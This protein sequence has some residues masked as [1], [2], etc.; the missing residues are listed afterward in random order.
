LVYS[1]LSRNLSIKRNPYK[2]NP[3]K[4]VA[5]LPFINLGNDT[6]DQYIY[7]GIRDEIFNNLRKVSTLRVISHTTVEQ[8][9]NTT[10]TIREIGKELDVNYIVKGSGQKSGNTSL[11][12]VSLIEVSSDKHIWTDSY[13]LEL[14]DIKDLFKNQSQVAQI[15][16]S[17]LNATITPEEKELIEKVPTQ[18]KIAYKLYWKA[19]SYEKDYEKSRDLS[20]YQTAVNL[21][22][23]TLEIDTIFARAYSGLALTYWSRYY[24]ETYFKQKFL[25]SCHILADK[26]LSFDDKLEEAYYLKGR[27]YQENGTRYAYKAKMMG[28]TVLVETEIHDFVL[29]KGWIGKGTKGIPSQIQW[30]FETDEA[31]TKF[32][33]VLEYKLPIP[34][35]SSIFDKL[36][37]KP[38][39]IKIIEKSL[40][41]L[42]QKF[43]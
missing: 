23:Y 40:Q 27:Y 33:Y 38:Q 20:S 41:N 42:N 17:E 34:L 4:S 25:D 3:E 37:M 12:R 35:L 36:I 19:N 24:S 29:N 22:K 26:A 1:A 10:K 28:L 43:Q 13:E 31:G 14:M 7:D 6:T 21:Y 8:Y 15:I 30:I 39:W 32:T 16:A 5:V 18:N 9:R 11:L 2:I